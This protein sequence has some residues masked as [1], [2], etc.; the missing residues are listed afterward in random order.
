MFLG[1]CYNEALRAAH[2]EGVAPGRV[3]VICP[4]WPVLAV[5]ELRVVG[6]RPTEEGEEWILAYRD[7]LRL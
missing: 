1:R 5:G 3:R 4:P 7:Y 2:S 6:I